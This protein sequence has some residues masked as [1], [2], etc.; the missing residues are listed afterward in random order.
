MNTQPGELLA[1]LE[2]C[3]DSLETG[4]VSTGGR[5]ADE[6]NQQSSNSCVLVMLQ[7][8]ADHACTSDFIR[9]VSQSREGLG[10]F[11]LHK[12]IIPNLV[13]LLPLETGAHLGNSVPGKASNVAPCMVS[14][15]VGSNSLYKYTWQQH[16]LGTDG[17]LMCQDAVKL[18][19]NRLERSR[20]LA[21]RLLYEHLG[22]FLQQPRVLQLLLSS[23]PSAAS[24]QRLVY[25]SL[26]HLLK[27]GGA[28]S[29]ASAT[30]CCTYKGI[31]L[32]VPI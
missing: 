32:Q 15:A 26:C 19:H 29:V 20:T 9:Q 23:L 7:R 12:T 14:E 3:L 25:C 28:P 30:T 4:H 16:G 1:R 21:H 2:A 31:L 24:R 27:P 18:L 22:I 8:T 5:Q 10:P 6:G 11:V 13:L 17:V